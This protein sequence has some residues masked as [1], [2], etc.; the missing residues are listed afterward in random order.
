LEAEGP[1][2]LL[3]AAGRAVHADAGGDDAVL[4]PRLPD[5]VPEPRALLDGDV[6]LP[7]ELP[8]VGDPR[9]ED[10]ERVHLDRPARGER[11]PVVGDVVRREGGEDVARTRAP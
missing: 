8:D 1:V 7:A 10:R 3:E 4:L 6:E 9:G 5:E 11:E 2:A